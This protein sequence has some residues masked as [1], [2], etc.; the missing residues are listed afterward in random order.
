MLKY[1]HTYKQY[2]TISINYILYIV[3]IL[4]FIL[5]YYVLYF[6]NQLNTLLYYHRTHKCVKI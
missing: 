5:I 3:Y 1:D 6:K 4:V 2:D